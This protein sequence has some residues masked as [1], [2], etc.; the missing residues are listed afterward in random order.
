MFAIVNLQDCL[1][2]GFMWVVYNYIDVHV[3][4]CLE[5]FVLFRKKD[6]VIVAFILYQK[7]MQVFSCVFV[8]TRRLLKPP[9]NAVSLPSKSTNLSV[10]SVISR[11]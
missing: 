4:S 7:N 8:L 3:S 9:Y 1:A 10:F 2:S 11:N 5:T 6:A